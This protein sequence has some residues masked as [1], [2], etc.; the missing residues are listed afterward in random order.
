MA[1]KKKKEPRAKIITNKGLLEM[2]EP[3]TLEFEKE[4]IKAIRR[5]IG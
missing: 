3:E 1:R 2:E 5:Y 4:D